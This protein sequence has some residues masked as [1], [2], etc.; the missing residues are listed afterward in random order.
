MTL[1]DRDGSKGSG[2]VFNQWSILAGVG[3]KRLVVVISLALT[4][5]A[6]VGDIEKVQP[7]LA[8]RSNK[9]PDA[10][11]ECLMTDLSVN[12][13]KVIIERKGSSIKALVP[14]GL[15]SPAPALVIADKTSHGTKVVLRDGKANNPFPFAGIR[16]TVSGCL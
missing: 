12:Q 9:D 13:S 15:A 7:S 5:C 10:F 3:M 11:M 14:Q 8:G 16:S 6:G 2:F 4:G 1:I